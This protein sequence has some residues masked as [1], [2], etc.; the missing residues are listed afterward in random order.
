MF[1]FNEEPANNWMSGLLLGNG[2]YGVMIHGNINEEQ[3]T[4][5]HHHS[6]L[7]TKNM[8]KIPFMADLLSELREIIVERNYKEA[9]DFFER[10]AIERGYPGLTMSDYFHPIYSLEVKH[11]KVT[12]IILKKD[13][14]KVIIL[15]RNMICPRVIYLFHIKQ[16]L[17]HQ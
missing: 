4:V 14:L 15:L 11:L 6:F 17:Y 10:K 16:M 9:I 13:T 12:Q 7:K 3:I 2:E 8:N 5:S 1:G